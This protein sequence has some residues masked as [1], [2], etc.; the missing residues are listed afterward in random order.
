MK[1]L[2]YT[3]QRAFAPAL[4]VVL[5]CATSGFAMNKGELVD[6]LIAIGFDRLSIFQ[7]SMILTPT[8]R[9][10]ILQAITLK[11]WPIISPLMIGWFRKF[12]GIRVEK[13]G[14]AI[15]LNIL[16]DKTG[17][18]ILTWDDFNKINDTYENKKIV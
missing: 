15:A 12:R 18:E 6:E 7:P 13:L 16:S 5:A 10:G 9:Y 4:A 17:V 11:V 14:N 3:S 1:L 8:N 2:H